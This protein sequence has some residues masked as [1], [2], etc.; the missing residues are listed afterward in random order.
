MLSQVFM[1]L[2]FDED[3]GRPENPNENNKVKS[4][5]NK[6]RKNREESGELQE[7]DKKKNRQ[8]L[9]TKMREEVFLRM[10]ALLILLVFHSFL[11]FFWLLK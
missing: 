8:E 2:T 3:L 7:R 10:I 6:K 4:K 9:V 11:S 5:K 1:Y